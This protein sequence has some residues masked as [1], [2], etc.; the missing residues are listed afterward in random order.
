MSK[1]ER[2]CTVP[3]AI[4]MS[5]AVRIKAISVELKCTLLSSA[6]GRSIRSSLCGEP[7]REDEG[8]AV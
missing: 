3:L 2:F 7:I 6:T 4:L 5:R 8:G 1:K